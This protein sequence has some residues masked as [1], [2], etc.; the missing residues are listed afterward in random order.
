MTD[1]SATTVSVARSPSIDNSL[2]DAGIICTTDAHRSS[3]RSL[4]RI[5]I[6]RSGVAKQVC[7]VLTCN[8]PTPDSL[9]QRVKRSNYEVY[10]WKK[11]LEPTKS[12]SPA[13]IHNWKV[14]DGALQ[15]VLMTK[16]P[17]PR[18]LPELTVCHCNI[19]TCH[20]ADYTCTTNNNMSLSRLHLYNQQQHATEPTTHVQPTTTCH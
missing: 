13:P 12:L 16:D 7:F 9:Q 4:V 5:D 15:H 8:D 10:V 11:A 1:T 20:R 2:T 3:V 18:G 14:R 6:G 19:S 17:A